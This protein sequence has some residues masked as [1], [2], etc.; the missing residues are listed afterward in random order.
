MVFNL[1]LNFNSMGGTNTF[2]GKR[3]KGEYLIELFG[4]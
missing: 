3:D 2:Q 1:T 4:Q